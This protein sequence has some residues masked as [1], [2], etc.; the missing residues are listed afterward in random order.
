MVCNLFTETDE[1]LWSKFIGFLTLERKFEPQE[2]PFPRVVVQDGRMSKAINIRKSPSSTLINDSSFETM[3][4]PRV[5]SNSMRTSIPPRGERD[6][7]GSST[8]IPSQ[9]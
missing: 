1:L 7:S 4:T 2:L 5:R 9:A 8:G 6:D 3:M